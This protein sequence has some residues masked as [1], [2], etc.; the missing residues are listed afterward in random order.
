MRRCLIARELFLKIFFPF[1][2][3]FC[4]VCAERCQSTNTNNEMDTIHG[5]LQ[6]WGKTAEQWKTNQTEV[7]V[8]TEISHHSGGDH[9]GMSAAKQTKTDL[10]T[11]KKMQHGR[12]KIASVELTGLLLLSRWLTMTG[13]AA[14]ARITVICPDTQQHALWCYP[15][16]VQWAVVTA[17]LFLT[18][19]SE[20]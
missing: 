2:F 15:T 5:C 19:P 3:F 14:A 4:S 16:L 7:Y 10:L 8:I 20:S 17:R 1:F 11:L 18:R 13:A 12:V 6:S 9:W